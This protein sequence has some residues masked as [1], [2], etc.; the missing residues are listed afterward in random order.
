MTT[1]EIDRIEYIAECATEEYAPHMAFEDF[2]QE[3][4][5][6][7]AIRLVSEIKRL[8]AKIEESLKTFE[9]RPMSIDKSAWMLV[10]Q[11]EPSELVARIKFDGAYYN[12]DVAADDGSVL[13]SDGGL[14]E[15]MRRAEEA[16]PE[17]RPIDEILRPE[18]VK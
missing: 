11:K 6:H 4:T 10:S 18:S 16:A 17:I 3:M 14:A 2:V 15:A 8:R 7:V 13:Y 1:E 12:W 9:W 5:P